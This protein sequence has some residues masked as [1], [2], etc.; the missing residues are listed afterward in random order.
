[1]CPMGCLVRT[2]GFPDALLDAH[3]CIEVASKKPLDA[4]SYALNDHLH[5]PLR[6]SFVS[7]RVRSGKLPP[8]KETSSSPSVV[9]VDL[10]YLHRQPPPNTPS[11][12]LACAGRHR[13]RAWRPSVMICSRPS[14]NS[15]TW[16][17]TPSAMIR[18][19]C[20]RSYVGRGG[21][22][23]STSEQSN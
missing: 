8:L 3:F 11:S 15:K 2:G 20:R 5:L 10:V 4:A 13:R 23:P 22:C 12:P 9:P 21:G 18:W 19:I 14:T 17:S 7:A 6:S 16:S 1:V